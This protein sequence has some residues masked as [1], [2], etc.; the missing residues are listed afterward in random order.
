MS[1]PRSWFA[2][3]CLLLVLSAT[4]SFAHSVP[5]AMA[6][7]PD[8]AGE[9]SPSDGKPAIVHV[10]GVILDESGGLLP[11][12]K[13]HFAG[14]TGSAT[15]VVADPTGSFRVDLPAGSYRVSAV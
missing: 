2:L 6:S 12:A 4:P 7:L 15:D 11:G 1:S 14:E 9:T 8:A 5:S 13:V 10:E 3:P